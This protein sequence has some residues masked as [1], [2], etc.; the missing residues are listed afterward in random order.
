MSDN[1]IHFF[2][3]EHPGIYRDFIHRL[4]WTCSDPGAFVENIPAFPRPSNPL[5]WID[6]VVVK[7]FD[8]LS[9]RLRLRSDS[10]Y[11]DGFRNDA[12]GSQWYEVGVEALCSQHLIPGSTF[13][14]FDGSY[15]SLERISTHTRPHLELGESNFSDAMEQLAR[16]KGSVT[17]DLRPDTARSLLVLTQM[18]S[19]SVRFEE[20]TLF[21]EENWTNNIIP[22]SDLIGLED[23]WG[24]FSEALIH[25]EQDPDPDHFRLPKNKQNITDKFGIIKPLGILQHRPSPPIPISAVSP[26]WDKYARGRMLAEIFSVRINKVGDQGSLGVYGTIEIIDGLSAQYIFNV[27]EN[28]AESV[29]PDDNITLTGPDRSIVAAD[30]FT[31]NI[32]IQG[33]R[34]SASPAENIS[35]GQI[36]WNYYDTTNK[37]NQ[38]INRPLVTNRTFYAAVEYVVLDDAFLARVKVSLTKGDVDNIANIY[39]SIVAN[40]GFGDVTLFKTRYSPLGVFE[41]AE[42]PLS[43]STIAVSNQ[44]PL[45]ITAD[46]KNSSNDE[47]AHG[48]QVFTPSIHESET[49]SIAGKYGE[50][51]VTVS[52]EI[53][54]NK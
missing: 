13:V 35:R 14:G 20:I 21:I 25:T 41:N 15:A 42:I 53:M 38:L 10:L 17:A 8:S 9:L 11:L 5:K 39:G 32:D 31:I 2:V 26:P 48:N 34:T 4:R 16:L 54:D 18:I 52:W 40:N 22:S 1:T 45:V 7:G 47:I 29:Y 28:K 43:R 44:S 23:A 30:S 36:L 33:K 12:E 46:L 6:V 19:E 37:Y 49:A 3:G 24:A 27:E 51:T 50:I